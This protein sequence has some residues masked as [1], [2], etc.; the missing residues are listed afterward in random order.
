MN[1]S[2][3][4]ARPTGIY[5]CPQ[6][7]TVAR[8]HQGNFPHSP[9]MTTFGNRNSP[10]RHSSPRVGLSSQHPPYC[11]RS[12]E[13]WR[14]LPF[15]QHLRTPRRR[16]W[17]IPMNNR[18]RYIWTPVH[19]ISSRR[20]PSPRR[21]KVKKQ[22]SPQKDAAR[23][24]ALT[25]SHS[26]YNSN[27]PIWEKVSN[28]TTEKP[29]HVIRDAPHWSSN[30]GVKLAP[31]ILWLALSSLILLSTARTTH[32]TQDTHPWSNHPRTK[33]FTPHVD[34]TDQ[35][36]FLHS[37]G[38]SA[39]NYMFWTELYEL[40]VNNLIN[41]TL[42]I[43]QKPCHAEPPQRTF[44]E[45]S[46]DTI[47]YL[48]K[49]YNMT[50]C[51]NSDSS[52][53]LTKSLRDDLIDEQNELSKFIET[54]IEHYDSDP[55]L[56]HERSEGLSI[57]SAAS[58]FF[59]NFLSLANLK[60]SR[61]I[62]KRILEMENEID[63]LQQNQHNIFDSFNSNREIV[64][65]KLKSMY[66]RFNE[67]F[68][69]ISL[70]QSSLLNIEVT[71]SKNIYGQ[72]A[73]LIE[74]LQIK[75][76]IFK[77]RSSLRELLSQDF[78]LTYLLNH[79]MV[80]QSIDSINEKLRNRSSPY[81]IDNLPLQ[82][83]LKNVKFSMTRT[84]ENKIHFAVSFPL[85]R[86]ND[87][88]FLY[89]LIRTPIKLNN[90]S[91]SVIQ[92]QLGEFTH[93][94]ILP[95]QGRISMIQDHQ[96][97]N[98]LY[99]TDLT[100]EPMANSCVYQIFQNNKEMIKNICA[101]SIKVHEELKPSISHLIDKYFHAQNLETELI[102]KCK[103]KND[104]ILAPISDSLLEIPNYCSLETK[105]FYIAERHQLHDLATLNHEI[106]EIKLQSSVAIQMLYNLSSTQLER[107][108]TIDPNI[109]YFRDKKLENILNQHSGTQVSLKQ[110][111]REITKQSLSDSFFL[112]TDKVIFTLIAINVTIILIAIILLASKATKVKLCAALFLE[113]QPQH[114]KCHVLD[115]PD[116][117]SIDK[118]HFIQCQS[119][120]QALYVIGSVTIAFAIFIIV[121][122]IYN[123]YKRQNN[124]NMILLN[125]TTG[126]YSVSLPLC[127]NVKEVINTHISA[128]FYPSKFTLVRTGCKFLLT[129][130]RG[131]VSIGNLH[132]K[133]ELDFKSSLPTSLKKAIILQK[134]LDDRNPNRLIMNFLA[135]S[136]EDQYV[137]LKVCKKFCSCH[138][139]S[140][141][142]KFD[143]T[144]HNHHLHPNI[145][146]TRYHD[147]LIHPSTL[148]KL[149]LEGKSVSP[150]NDYDIIDQSSVHPHHK[151]AHVETIV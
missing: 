44:Y 70:S 12:S 87:I 51:L 19:H 131:D 123:N 151:D 29:P 2:R 122:C 133:D 84:R 32:A 60:H 61:F 86:P 116:G 17:H 35:G 100:L 40:D 88:G 138:L 137:R 119:A 72:I 50:L 81:R 58:S 142:L 143:F 18:P 3:N 62:K 98:N 64:D 85:T 150:E 115:L 31:A 30:F 80:R 48:D 47:G 148:S 125:L 95:K 108:E 93:A 89:K 96:I 26:S 105:N 6:K 77:V 71:R 49:Y 9:N 90:Q 45:H 114:V 132:E 75:Q 23:A 140:T 66:I 56:R 20:R 41:Q 53:L 63:T 25:T 145:P 34:R 102:I 101:Y 8:S 126:K 147:K 111:T 42:Q 92:L 4:Q 78:E 21:K 104:T 13:N 124:R 149:S 14:P 144:P 74:Y 135:V 33:T 24:T 27:K 99:P 129:F 43:R 117:L 7:R 109:E 38:K 28:Q 65:S 103:N 15:H 36:L 1:Q 146:P 16:R 110:I 136:N 11:G 83:L 130:D 5:L 97:K 121:Y 55:Q 127:R 120:Q 10:T 54:R 112:S 67:I 46:I 57:V 94:L 59:G 39:S 106:K 22:K 37:M 69:N 134:M 73:S 118:D 107:L 52:Y 79:D 139:T 76:T 141:S 68:N 113:R 91:N 82:S 128:N